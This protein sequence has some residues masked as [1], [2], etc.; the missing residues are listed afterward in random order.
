[1]P[2]ADVILRSSDLVDF[3]VRRSILATSS[4]FFGD[5]FSIPQPSDH[6]VVDGLPVVHLPEDVEVLNSLVT[7]LYP[8]P[9]EIPDSD[10]KILTLLAASQK[11]DMTTVQSSIRAEIGRRGLLSPTG[12]ESFRLF[13][14]ACRK[15]LIPEMKAAARLTLGHP[16]TFEYLGEA[17]RSFE[18]W[19]LFDLSRFRLCCRDSITSCFRVFGNGS[20]G[21]SKVWVGCP[22]P[23][24]PKIRPLGKEDP[25]IWLDEIISP[26]I[27]QRTSRMFTSPL[28]TPSSFREEYLE[29]LRGHIS[30]SDCSFC[31]KTHTLKGEE[32][33]GEVENQLAQAWEVQYRFRIE[34]P[35]SESTPPPVSIRYF[36]LESVADLSRPAD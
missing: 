1:M 36:T 2:D 5:L 29:A 31:M 15:S 9:P 30:E 11:Y 21:P 13:A 23:R 16:M 22:T 4:P 24:H 26:K 18:G 35:G 3:R 14:N 28:V 8:V 19:A 34:L 27:V 6:E 32:F 10:D 17:L 33:W 25:P 20:S 7:M 12:A